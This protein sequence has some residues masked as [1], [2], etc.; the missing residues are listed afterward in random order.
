MFLFTSYLSLFLEALQQK[1]PSQ[2][3]ANVLP[4]YS[5]TELLKCQTEL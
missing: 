2:V 5:L 1:H 3:N 4:L